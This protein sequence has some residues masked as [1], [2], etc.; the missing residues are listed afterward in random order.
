[1]ETWERG[2]LTAS[3]FATPSQLMSLG[4]I[5]ATAIGVEMQWSII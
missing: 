3:D 4:A 5:A 1:M 2:G